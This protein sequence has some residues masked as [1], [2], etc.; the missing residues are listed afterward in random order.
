MPTRILIIDDEQSFVRSLMFALEETDIEAVCAYS[1]EDGLAVVARECPDIV[2]LDLRLPGIGGME[3]LEALTREHPGLPVVMISAHGDTRA[4]VQAAKAGA[5]DYL[6]KPFALD[7]L[8]HLIGNTTE[9][10]RMRSEL[11]YHRDRAASASASGLVGDSETMAQ[12]WQT[13]QRVAASSAGRILLQGESGTGKA[14]VARAIHSS[15]PRTA[16]AFV[17]INCAALPDQLIEA[18]LFGSEKGAYTGAHQTRIGLVALADGGTLFLDEVGEL[19]LLLQAKLLHFLE[20]GSYRPLGSNRPRTANARI[21]AATNR[22]LEAEVRE[23]RFREDLFFRLHVIELLIPPLRERGNDIDLMLEQFAEIQ[24]R[25]ERCQP[26]HYALETLEHLRHYAWPGN[27]RELKNLVERLTILYPGQLI[28]PSHLPVEMQRD[29]LHPDY[30]GERMR[31]TE[32]QIVMDALSET[33]GHKGKAAEFLGL[34]R[35][36]FK[37]RLQRLGLD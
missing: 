32:R 13:I 33:G 17:E 35:H 6:T 7:E 21:I 20:D 29:D 30:L 27:V 2:L 5:A 34:S 22:P 37:R 16:E 36:A 15:S 8:L 3:V 12:L 24:A 28:E 23:G 19:P 26:I 25:E 11:D 4:A 10:I 14:L 18:E 9:R 31:C 1:G